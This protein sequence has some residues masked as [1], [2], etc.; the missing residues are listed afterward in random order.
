MAHPDFSK[1]AAHITAGA[2]RDALADM[3]NIASPTGGEAAMAHYLVDRMARSGLDTDLQMVDEGRPNAVGQ[4]RGAGTGVN[5]LFTGHMDTS[6][7]GT[8][9]YLSGAGFKPKAVIEDGWL[10]GLGS[11]NMK[12]GLAAALVAIEALVK[13]NIKLAGD[14]SFGGVVGE[15]EKTAIEEFQ[16]SAYSGYGVGSKHLVTHG[17]T[18]DYAMLVEPTGLKISTANLGCLWARIT[19]EGTV[20]HSAMSNRSGVVNAIS[21]MHELQSD[22]AD[23][24]R[25]YEESDIYMDE[26]PNVT[27]ASIRGGDPWRLSRNPY[28]CSLYLDIRTLPGQSAD[29]VK[30]Q[31]RAVLRAFS[32]RKGIAE[33]ALFF[34][35][36]DPATV[37]DQI[38]PVVQALGVAQ[39]EVSGER[40]ASI[41]RRPGADAVHFNAYGVP[42]VVFGP[43]GRTHPSSKGRSM[44]AVGEHVLIEDVLTASRIYLATALD[45]CSRP[46][47]LRRQA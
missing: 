9:I 32:A 39:Q 23:W 5:L 41:I 12:S 2:A 28:S 30:R 43:G 10:W 36:T 37:I 13:S 26:R 6:Y 15:I 22:I 14:I 33:P 16:G 27:I 29:M 20:S 40:P 19:V 17:V 45:I 25:A 7:D 3:V 11:N 24:A 34:Y 1:V 46:G 44:H 42:C 8:E 35:V 21:V 38:L 4:L 47:E 31:L 18:A